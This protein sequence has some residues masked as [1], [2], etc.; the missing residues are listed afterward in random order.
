MI[1]NE[2]FMLN[3]ESIWNNSYVCNTSLDVSTDIGPSN[4]YWKVKF[5]DK[6]Y[7]ILDNG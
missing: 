1:G 7:E 3:S 6:H 5:V 4:P 2:T